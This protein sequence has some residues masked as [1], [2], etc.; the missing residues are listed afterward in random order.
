MGTLARYTETFMPHGHG[1]DRPAHIID[2]R[3]LCK[4]HL[5]YG[6]VELFNYEYITTW[7]FIFLAEELKQQ[8]RKPRERF[9]TGMFA[10]KY[11]EKWCV[12]LLCSMPDVLSFEDLIQVNTSAQTTCQCQT[13]H[14]FAHWPPYTFLASFCFLWNALAQHVFY[15]SLNLI[16]L[17]SWTLSDCNSH[18]S[19]LNYTSASGWSSKQSLTTNFDTTAL[20]ETLLK[21]RDCDQSGLYEQT[22]RM[23]ATKG[24]QLN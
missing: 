21:I 14:E 7:S 23:R 22:S 10:Q 15:P 12:R 17:T 20:S 6:I 1:I 9:L 16:N 11:F 5:K 4:I 2:G 18:V 8:F 19:K 24:R 13:L 3:R